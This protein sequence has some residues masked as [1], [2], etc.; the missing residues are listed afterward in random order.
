M[1]ENNFISLTQK[2]V[3]HFLKLPSSAYSES[4][5]HFFFEKSIRT[6][7]VAIYTNTSYLTTISQ[8]INKNGLAAVRRWNNNV[9]SGT[10]RSVAIYAARPKEKQGSML[11]LVWNGHAVHL[12]PTTCVLQTLVLS[13]VRDINRPPLPSPLPSPTRYP[14]L[15]NMWSSLC[16]L[17]FETVISHYRD[18]H[19]N[20]SVN[21][22]ARENC[23]AVR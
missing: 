6:R 17:L 4:R 2:T 23:L 10:A 16:L 14:P 22:I 18:S 5:I 11:S 15:M 12:M 8:K 21:I 19:L 20:Y 13:L 1:F 7:F 9:W 3:R